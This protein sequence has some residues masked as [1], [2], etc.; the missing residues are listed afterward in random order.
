MRNSLR[1]AYP[2][3]SALQHQAM[4]RHKFWLERV[5]FDL[6]EPVFPDLP[7]AVDSRLGLLRFPAV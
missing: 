4:Q 3:R 7:P 6:R 2:T 5:Q 1:S